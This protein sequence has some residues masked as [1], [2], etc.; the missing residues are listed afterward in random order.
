MA[1]AGQV[2]TGGSHDS[3]RTRPPGRLRRARADRDLPVLFRL[4][5]ADGYRPGAASRLAGGGPAAARP[6]GD[7]TA[8][9]PGRAPRPRLSGD[10]GDTAAGLA[11]AARAPA[12][13][14]AVPVA[15]VRASDASGSACSDGS[16]CAGGSAC[17]DGSCCS[18]GTCCSGGSACSACSAC[19][20]AARR[21][22]DCLVAV[23]G[24]GG[25]FSCQAR[26]VGPGAT[27]GGVARRRGRSSAGPGAAAGAA[28]FG[29]AAA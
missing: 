12:L 17:S 8:A 13:A 20:D 1:T 19:S 28:S 9:R 24:R 27:A 16:A 18:G 4:P 25:T 5:A 3:R 11:A 10:A 15:V 6:A 22:A 7:G 23:D 2:A 21:D 14:F 29:P 26:S